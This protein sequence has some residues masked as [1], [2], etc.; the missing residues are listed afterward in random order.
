MQQNNNYSNHSMELSPMENFVYL[1]HDHDSNTVIISRLL[2]YT[3]LVLIYDVVP[4]C[5]IKVMRLKIP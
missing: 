3:L 1:I 2:K 4:S 5:Q